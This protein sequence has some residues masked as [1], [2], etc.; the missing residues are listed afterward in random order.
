MAGFDPVLDQA[1][2]AGVHLLAHHT[3]AVVARTKISKDEE[4]RRIVAA[5]SLEVGSVFP[6]SERASD[7]ELMEHHRTTTAQ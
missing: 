4:D 7:R 5:I 1:A 6:E 3:V 2:D